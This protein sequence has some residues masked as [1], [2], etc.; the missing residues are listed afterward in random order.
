[1][2]T[3]P[4]TT[5][6]RRGLLALAMAVPIWAGAVT[7]ADQPLFSTVSVPGNLALALSVEFP[8]ALSPAYPNTTAYSANSTYIGYFDP[9]KCYVYQYNP[10]APANSYFAPVGSASSHACT[11]TTTRSLWSGN[12]LNWASMGALD[13]FR[14]V[15]TGGYRVTDSITDTVLEK[16]YNFNSGVP[17]ASNTPDKTITASTTIQSATPFT[18]SSATTKV[19]HQGA[20]MLITGTSTVSG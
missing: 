12:Y 4:I 1:M 10:F 16:A 18:W 19:W 3:T 7:L 20:A 9:E 11:R 2:N 6:V 8:T 13:T 5:I 15:L 14:S 17:Q